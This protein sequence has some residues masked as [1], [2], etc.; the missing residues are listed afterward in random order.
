MRGQEQAAVEPRL[1]APEGLD[2]RVRGVGRLGRQD[3]EPGAAHG[4]VA[5]CRLERAEIDQPAAR[6]IDQQRALLERPERPA[7]D[8]VGVPGG[9]RAVQA[10]HIRLGEQRFEGRCP[11]IALRQIDAIGQQGVVKA[12]LHVEAVGPARRRGA[13]PAQADDAE[14][15]AAQPADQGRAGPVPAGVRVGEQTGV[16]GDQAAG[17]PEHQRDRV[18][19]DLGGAVVGHVADRDPPLAAG[20][21]VDVVVADARPDQDPAVR[22]PLDQGAIDRHAVVGDQRIGRAPAIVRDAVGGE[23]VVHR[24]LELGA[25]DLALD[26]GVVLEQR[27]GQQNQHGMG[28]NLRH[29]PGKVAGAAGPSSPVRARSRSALLRRRLRLA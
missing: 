26:Q 6:G 14:A 7:V 2:Q 10:D 25:E 1:A 3:V 28:P 18:I 15:G 8:Q 20:G 23:L 19:G 22:Q 12:D 9:Q 17:E 21:D 27:V 13:D 16:V 24:E 4:A 11:A 29:E 5:Q